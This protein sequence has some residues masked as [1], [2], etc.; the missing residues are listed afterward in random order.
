MN[1]QSLSLDGLSQGYV[2]LFP[3]NPLNFGASDDAQDLIDNGIGGIPQQADGEGYSHD[4]QLHADASSSTPVKDPDPGIN[5]STDT[6][7]EVAP[8]EIQPVFEGKLQ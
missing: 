2:G 4:F 5:C 7:V 8:V 3:D 1:H 6:A